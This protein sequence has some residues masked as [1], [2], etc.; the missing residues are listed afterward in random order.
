[1]TQ[2]DFGGPL[3]PHKIDEMGGMTVGLHPGMHSP[4][5]VLLWFTALFYSSKAFW[6]LPCRGRSGLARMDPLISPGTPSYHVHSIHG[7]SGFTMSADAG[8]LK[9]APCTSC[10]VEQ[11]KSAYWTPALYFMHENND[12][13][14]VDS[15]GGMLVYY[16]LYGDNVTAFPEGFR[17]I[18]GDPFQRDFQWPIPDPPQSE[19]AGSDISQAALRQK[20]VG[21]NCLN[22]ANPPEPSLGRHFLPNK[23]FIDQHC[24]DG[25]RLEIMFPSCWNGHAADSV[26]HKSHLA[27]PSLVM[28]GVCPPGFE[29]RVVSMFYETIWDTTAFAAQAGTF[30]LSNGDPTGFGYHGDFMNGWESGV[31]E[32]AV[33]QCTNPSGMVEDCPLFDLQA[34][35]KQKLCTVEIPAELKNEDVHHW[36]KALPHD[37][38]V[39]YGPAYASPIVFYTNPTPSVTPSGCQSPSISSLSPHKRSGPWK[40]R[41]GAYKH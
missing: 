33:A 4:L 30:V 25:L 40:H 1:M 20:A 31:L 26:D 5:H 12:T 10:A 34:E 13:E 2:S 19:W 24:A 36:N 17:M 27:Y 15:V 3:T 18:A 6:R 37:L 38:A 7:S 14:L 9:Q 29:A 35:S 23:T 28:D 22:Y 16:L 41:H 21:F 39:Q 11:D 8:T 32:K